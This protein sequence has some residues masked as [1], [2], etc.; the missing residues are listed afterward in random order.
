MCVSS[1]DNDVHY[2]VFRVSNVN[3]KRSSKNIFL[4]NFGHYVIRFVCSFV[5]PSVTFHV[6]VFG[7]DRF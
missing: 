2:G 1:N 3:N 5:R 7:Q 4:A 6:K